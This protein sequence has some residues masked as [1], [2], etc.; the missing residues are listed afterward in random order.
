MVILKIDKRQVNGNTSLA[1][2]QNTISGKKATAE[3]RRVMYL[4]ETWNDTHDK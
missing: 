3:N 2:T 4:V 1:T